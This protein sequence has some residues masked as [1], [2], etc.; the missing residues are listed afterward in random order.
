MT[1]EA[2]TTALVPVTPPA[3]PAAPPPNPPVTPAIPAAQPTGFKTAIAD[4][5]YEALPP[6]Q[7]ARYSRT[8]GDGVNGSTWV[9][10]AELEA[11]AGPADPAAA[12]PGET[13]S[14]T[15]DGKLRVGEYELSSDDIAMLMQTKAAADLKATQIPVDASGYESKLPES[16]KLPEG[17]DFRP[18]PNDPAFKDFQAIAKKIGLSQSEFSDLYGAYVAKT[19]A[20]E[21]AFRNSMK[22]ELDALGAHA[23]MRV[24]ALETWLRGTVGDDIAKHMRA[25][26]FSAK[27][28][29][30]LERIQNKMTSQGAA[31]FSQ[32]HREPNSGGR[33]PLS[34]MSEQERTFRRRAIRHS[35]AGSMKTG[36][37][38]CP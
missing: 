22:A 6:D 24:T 21:A 10:R 13:P 34:S 33:G 2:A 37:K 23:T 1:T 17:L 9:E 38:L 28:V 19:V 4:G 20:S 26:M 29:E 30:G 11:S 5:A 36:E 18:D 8:R 12:K 31:S 7:Q 27:I 35:Q 15:A 32:A 14:V 25:G 3:A 16:L